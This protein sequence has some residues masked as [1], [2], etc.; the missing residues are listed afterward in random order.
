VKIDTTRLQPLAGTPSA[1]GVAKP[2]KGDRATGAGSVDDSVGLSEIGRLA[3]K[4]DHLPDE[5]IQEL[6]REVQ[7]GTYQVDAQKVSER[8]VQSMLEK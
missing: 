6:R 5:R 4:I 1:E 7:S 2:N 8:L 3:A